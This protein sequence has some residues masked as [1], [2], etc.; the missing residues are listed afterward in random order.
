M[1]KKEL[2]LQLTSMYEVKNCVVRRVYGVSCG[3]GYDL[4]VTVMNNQTGEISMI[5]AHANNHGWFY[6]NHLRP[7]NPF[8]K[9][10]GS[11]DRYQS[12][13]INAWLQ[14]HALECYYNEFK[15]D[16]L[17]TECENWGVSINE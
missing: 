15:K 1:D 2:V 10:T 3:V 14:P 12:R 16:A 7:N 6:P 11:C 17:I 13:V 5:E 4:D 8:Y 9:Y